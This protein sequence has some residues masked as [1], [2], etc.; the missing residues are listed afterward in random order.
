MPTDFSLDFKEY[1]LID[2][3][4]SKYQQTYGVPNYN[5]VQWHSR[6]AKFKY[7][8]PFDEFAKQKP[9]SSKAKKK[10]DKSTV[11]KE[12]REKITHNRM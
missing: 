4:A 6:P 10:K 12:D 8:D 11:T 9:L 2:S 1:E 5:E 3:Y 7:I